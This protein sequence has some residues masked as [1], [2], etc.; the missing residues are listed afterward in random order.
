MAP[1]MTAAL[2]GLTRR[3]AHPQGVG[4]P[5]RGLDVEPVERRLVALPVDEV[6]R[7]R[8]VVVAPVVAGADQVA[9]AAGTLRAR[10]RLWRIRLD[11]IGVDVDRQVLPGIGCLGGEAGVGRVGQPVVDP[12]HADGLVGREGA[13]ITPAL[14]LREGVVAA[15]GPGGVLGSGRG[16]RQADDGGRPGL[17]PGRPEERRPPEGEDPAV[18]GDQPVP[19]RRSRPPCRRSACSA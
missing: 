4:E 11:L 8:R 13:R 3:P 17:L 14:A 9:G 12:D 7:C 15:D 19:A 6:D 10:Q 18:G 16:D 1:W 5:A 2:D